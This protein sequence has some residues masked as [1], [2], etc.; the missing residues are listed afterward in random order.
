MLKC[1]VFWSFSVHLPLAL[2]APSIG[3]LQLNG[4]E[5]NDDERP[6]LMEKIRERGERGSGKGIEEYY[7][8]Y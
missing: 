1:Y 2:L 8:F 5:G 3:L 6:D 4:S 7:M